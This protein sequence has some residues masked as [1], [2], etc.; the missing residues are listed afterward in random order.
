MNASNRCIVSS[1]GVRVHE[2]SDLGDKVD[3]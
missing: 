1:Q 2:K 3:E